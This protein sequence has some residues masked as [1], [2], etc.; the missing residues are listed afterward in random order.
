MDLVSSLQQQ[1]QGSREG[2]AI[3]MQA[4]HIYAVDNETP[5]SSTWNFSC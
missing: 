5:V 1:L 2:V 3:F 4:G